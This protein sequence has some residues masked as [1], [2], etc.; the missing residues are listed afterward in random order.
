[1][2]RINRIENPNMLIILSGKY[3][4]SASEMLIDCTYN[5]ENVLII[6]ENTMGALLGGQGSTLASIQCSKGWCWKRI[7]VFANRRR[8]F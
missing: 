3:S 7:D 6:G 5:L 1:M 8:S 2:K 4:A